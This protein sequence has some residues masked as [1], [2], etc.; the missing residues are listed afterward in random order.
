MQRNLIVPN[1]YEMTC[2][3]RAFP[4]IILF[5]VCRHKR[6][7]RNSSSK[8]SASILSNGIFLFLL[9]ISKANK[10]ISKKTEPPFFCHLMQKNYLI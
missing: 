10:A 3:R 5:I 1:T 6:F 2:G 7:P 8:P 4:T 9:L